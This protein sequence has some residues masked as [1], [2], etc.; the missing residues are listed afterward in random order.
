MIVDLGDRFLDELLDISE[1][2]SLLGIA[3]GYRCPTR[4]RTT[5][6]PDAMHI[7]LRDVGELV[8][9]DVF[10]LIDIDTTSRD[11]GR[12]E[13][14]SR[15]RLEV[16]ECFLSR[17]LCLVAV[18]RL[19]GDA[20]L[21][22]ELHDFIGS[23]LGACEDESRLDRLFLEEMEEEVGFIFLVYFVDALVDDINRRGDG[24]D[25][26]FRRIMQDCAR[27]LHDLRRHR[28]GEKERLLLLGK[29][30]QYLLHIVDKSHI[31]HPIRLI[32]DEYLDIAEV[33]ELLIDE[34]KESP[35]SRDQDVDTR[36]E[37]FDLC[38]LS[39][40]TEYDRGTE[41]GMTTVG[42]DALTDLARE[43]TSRS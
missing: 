4:T 38:A 37:G 27:E 25:R 19:R 32:E 33:D 34:V 21:G 20:V 9:D 22:E 31:E 35:R 2:R 3:E 39:D 11:I 12:N 1:I 17:G 26:H 30:S 42:D 24:R 23:V 14:P 7:G 13:H 15:L 29:Y 18:D 43:L 28:R 40:T 16:G 36:F 5:G 41:I 6:T 8:V 10:E